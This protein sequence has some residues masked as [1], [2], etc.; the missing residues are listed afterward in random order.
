MYGGL[1]KGGRSVYL[2]VFS[3]KKLPVSL[4]ETLACLDRRAKPNIPLAIGSPLLINE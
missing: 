1:T 2:M 3:V 4:S